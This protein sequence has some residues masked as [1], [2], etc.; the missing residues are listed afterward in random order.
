MLW[1]FRLAGI[2]VVVSLHNSLW[3]NG[4]PPRGLLKRL[5]LRLDSTFWRW[6]AAAAVGISPECVRQ[7]DQLTGGRHGGLYVMRPMMAPG[8]NT[9]PPPPP[10]S[11][12]PFGV[13]FVGRI[14]RYKG[15]FDI[16]EMARIAEQRAPGQVRWQWGPRSRIPLIGQACHPDQAW[17]RIG[18]EGSAQLTSQ[19][20]HGFEHGE[21]RRGEAERIRAQECREREAAR[22]ARLPFNDVAQ[23]CIALAPDGLVTDQVPLR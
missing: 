2:P 20:A 11:E 7:V 15:V 10:H 23:R 12:R 18:D 4:Y 17:A 19:Q 13:F 3:P 16:L 22:R 6:G 14:E 5:I 1:L 9:P 21:I 8:R